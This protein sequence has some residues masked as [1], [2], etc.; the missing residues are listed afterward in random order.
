MQSKFRGTGVA[1]VTPFT[2]GQIDF[3]ALERVVNHILEGGV[4]YLVVLGT[5]GESVTLSKKEKHE[6][7]E[8][9]VR[10]NDK[11]VPLVAGFGGNYTE[12]LVEDIKGFHFE[13]YDAILSVCPYYNRPTQEGLYQ[14]FI[15]V[16]EASPVPVLLYNVPS[17]TASNLN[18]ETTL[19]LS[20]ANKKIIGI[21]EASGDMRQVME[22]V[23]RKPKDFL[24]ISGDDN[25]TLPM[26]SFGADGLI[27]VVGN[28][29][30]RETSDLVRA[31]L[32][33]DFITA[34]RLHFQLMPVIDQ[35]F[36]D[37][38][39]AGIKGVLEILDL[40]GRE[41]RLPLMPV[42]EDTYNKLTK[43]IKGYDLPDAEQR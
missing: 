36:N 25:L 19:R 6:V 18:A 23:W 4:E 37:G 13:G 1:I 11:R 43:L 20:N 8:F 31:G 34:R 24:V 16:A 2:N 14:H 10:V 22:I 28:A 41:V 39:P 40:C 7:L 26:L 17:R 12:K 29:L 9:V 15:Q 27:S 30:P 35:I 38:N 33:D 32:N 42:R 3:D 21:K 5:T